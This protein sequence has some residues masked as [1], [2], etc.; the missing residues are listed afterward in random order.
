MEK[1]PVLAIMRPETYTDASED[2]AVAAGFQPFSVPVV[3]LKG[4]K[5]D[6]FDGF[7]KRVLSSK[8]DLVIFTSANGI[9]Y[10]L[11][12]LDGVG[13]K[14]FLDALKKIKIVAIGPTTRKK[15]E[16]YGLESSM[17]PGEYSSVGLV[18]DLGKDVSG[19]IID[20]P[21]SFYG[22]AVLV[23]GLIDAGATVHQT[24]VYTL[25][26]PEGALQDELIEKTIAGEIEAFAFTSTMMV[27][28]FMAL[29]DKIGDRDEVISQLN[30]AVVG[31]IGDPTAQTVESFGVT[32]DV[33]PDEFTFEALVSAMKEK[34]NQK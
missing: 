7:V 30:E 32:V 20:I 13:E 25:D 1:R 10:T 22:S 9:D 12:N 28:N 11:K 6:A 26:I 8:T 2:T 24:H 21:R 23:Q 4:M 14:D 18:N 17:M 33:V 27:K 19:K 29:A 5:D 16:S 3:T 15:L 31:A 34:M